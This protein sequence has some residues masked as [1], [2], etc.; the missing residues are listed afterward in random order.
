MDV[1]ILGRVR[2][3]VVAMD[4]QRRHERV[5]ARIGERRARSS[6]LARDVAARVRDRVERTTGESPEPVRPVGVHVFG[7]QPGIVV[8]RSAMEH[9]DVVSPLQR[10]PGE[11]ASREAGTADQEQLHA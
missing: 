6:E 10:E 4:R 7:I 11:R 9:G 8:P 5:E 3:D 2:P 1:V